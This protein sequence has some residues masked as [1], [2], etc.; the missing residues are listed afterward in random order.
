VTALA[1]MVLSRA[2]P[3][4]PPSWLPVLM[5]AEATPVSRGGTPKVPVVTAGAKISP[6]PAPVS[7][8]AGRM[9]VA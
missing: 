5:V 1:K 2:V 4:E 8:T 3:M 6:R 7:S 9:A